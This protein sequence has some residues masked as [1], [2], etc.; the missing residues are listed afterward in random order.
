MLRLTLD[1]IGVEQRELDS[2]DERQ[3]GL[4]LSVGEAEGRMETLL[5][6]ERGLAVLHQRLD[7]MY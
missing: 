6:K 2:F 7:E 3:R 5:A 4:Q 1:R